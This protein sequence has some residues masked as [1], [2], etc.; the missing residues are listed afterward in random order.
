MTAR[1]Y[2]AW[3]RAQPERHH[4]LHGE[5]FAMAGGSPRHAA[6]GAAITVELGTA[7]R[8]GPCRVFSSDLRVALLEGEHYVYPDVTVVCGKMELAAGTNDVATNPSVVVEILS[9]GTEAYDR[10]LKWDGYQGVASITDY[11]LVSQASARIEQFRRA[12]H[13]AWEYRVFGAGDRVTLTSGAGMDV[14]T[15][16]AGVFELEGN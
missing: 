7:F 15:V 4:F 11:L 2:L 10:G 14:Q 8:G 5:V 1:D 3:E 12:A 13:G 16:Y 6:L 9:K